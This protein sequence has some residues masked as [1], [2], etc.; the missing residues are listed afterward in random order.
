MPFG[1][2]VSMQNAL[3]LK[4]FLEQPR[5][6]VVLM[7]YKPDADALGSSLA[8]AAWLRKGNHMVTVIS[9]SDYPSFLN[10]MPGNDDV[11]VYQANR[12][13]VPTRAIAEADLVF[14]LDFS[15]LS[16][17]N[18]LGELVRQSSAKTVLVDHHLEPERFA[19]FEE[20]DA[21][22]ASTAELVYRLIVELG[23]EDKIDCCIAD[24]LY[25]GLMT[26]TG[27][28]R[29]NNTTHEVF[30]T[31]AAL[32]KRGANPHRVSKLIYDNNTLGRLRLMGYVLS[33]KLQVIPELKTAYI[34]LSRDEL[35][36]H[37]SQTGDTE[38]LV[39]YGLSIKDVILSVLIYER[40]DGSVKLSFRSIGDFSVNDLA[41]QHFEGGGHKNAA[42]GQS[43]LS[44][45]DTLAKFLSILPS[46]RDLLRNEGSITTLPTNQESKQNKA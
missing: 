10:W 16:R 4:D 17:I 33:Q 25:A 9:P 23:G 30:V 28:F 32:V 18:E 14:C 34:T 44:L 5:K 45:D 40:K 42:G 22:A 19:D 21:T 38:G 3:E 20:W 15:S 6:V 29:H 41:R 36:Q 12:P 8:L 37:E 11:I 26:D 39:N 24:C 2:S 13:G 43:S 31:A 46:Y 1:F 35:R 27:S 7:H